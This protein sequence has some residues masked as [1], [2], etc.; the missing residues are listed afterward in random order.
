MAQE[1]GS[2]NGLWH[3]SFYPI[4]SG[5]GV[6]L[7]LVVEA[8]CVARHRQSHFDSENVVALEVDASNPSSIEA[9][10]SF[11]LDAVVNLGVLKHKE[12]LR[13]PWQILPDGRRVVLISPAFRSL[14]GPLSQLPGSYRRDTK[15]SVRGTTGFH[16][17]QLHCLKFAGFFSWWA[18]SHLYKE[19]ELPE[20]QLAPIDKLIVPL[21]SSAGKRRSSPVGLN[22][23][24]VLEKRAAQ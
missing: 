14:Y 12:E 18:N 2:R 4:D 6:V 24:T 17:I 20:A 9:P 3:G 13:K 22:L 7:G 23:F 16:P 1:V 5:Q 21:A 19:T 10:R 11:N 15:Q 8:G